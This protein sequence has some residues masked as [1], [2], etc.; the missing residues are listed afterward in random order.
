MYISGNGIKLHNK[1]GNEDDTHIIHNKWI[2]YWWHILIYNELICFA[3]HGQILFFYN[4]NIIQSLNNM[5]MFTPRYIFTVVFS[6]EE[7]VTW[8][9]QPMSK[10]SVLKKGFSCVLTALFQRYCRKILSHPVNICKNLQCFECDFKMS[11]KKTLFLSFG[12]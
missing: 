6:F 1:G 9:H 7:Y 12:L 5:E 3:E 11:V 8:R 4:L 10:Q 2:M